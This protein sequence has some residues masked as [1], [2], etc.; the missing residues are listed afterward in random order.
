[1][2][3]KFNAITKEEWASCCR[4]AVECEEKYFV[5]EREIYLTS[6]QIIISLGEDDSSSDSTDIDEDEGELSGVEP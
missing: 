3:E 2:N 6:E 4:H 1:V 5:L